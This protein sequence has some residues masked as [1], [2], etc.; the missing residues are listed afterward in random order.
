VTTERRH[1]PLFAASTRLRRLLWI[2][3]G[4]IVGVAL[5][6][7]ILVWLAPQP[8]PV[9]SPPANSSDI[10]ISMNDANL[11]AVVSDSLTQAHLP[12]AVSNV[13]AH[14]QADNI[15]AISA[16]ADV[17]L[18]P[19]RLL[20]ATA[21]VAVVDGNLSLHIDKG[22]IGGLNLPSPVVATI[23][24]ALNQKFVTLGGLL[25]LGHSRYDVSGVTTS[26]NSLVLSVG[27][28]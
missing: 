5:T 8:T 12:F 26:D 7:F 14:I 16:N 13:R 28:L 4:L 21:H 19:T 27:R 1:L 24:S 6:L 25:V 15:V 20:S 3:V 9:S 23:E 22:T 18:L 11:A 10:R 17:P 2:G